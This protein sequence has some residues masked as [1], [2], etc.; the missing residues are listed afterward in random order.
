M[1]V[2]FKVGRSSCDAVEM[3]T[4]MSNRDGSRMGHS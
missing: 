3:I 2:P 4:G 1:A